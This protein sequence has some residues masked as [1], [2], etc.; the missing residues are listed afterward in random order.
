MIYWGGGQT[1]DDIKATA[2]ALAVSGTRHSLEASLVAGCSLHSD[3][4]V[5]ELREAYGL[6]GGNL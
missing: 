4:A 1:S 5:S 3:M 6:S 2:I